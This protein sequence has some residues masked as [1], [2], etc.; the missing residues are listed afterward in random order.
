[1]RRFGRGA[2]ASLGQR[3]RLHVAHIDTWSVGRAH[4]FR[5]FKTNIGKINAIPKF[6][7]GRA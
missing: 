7:A 2:L 4:E 3:A 6:I 5:L 1:M